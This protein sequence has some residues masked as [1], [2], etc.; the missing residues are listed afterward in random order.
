MNLQ[1]KLNA[2]HKQR[3]YKASKSYWKNMFNSTIKIKVTCK[4]CGYT[5]AYAGCACGRCGKLNSVVSAQAKSIETSL[6]N[7]PINDTL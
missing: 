2:R 1:E 5:K 6:R 3:A 7:L 4:S